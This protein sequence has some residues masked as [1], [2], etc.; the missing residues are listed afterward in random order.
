MELILILSAVVFFA[1]AV[2]TFS[3]FAGAMV[4]ITVGAHF[5][6]IERLVPVWVLINLVMNSY[7]ILRHRGHVAWSLIIKQ[8]LPFMCAG[9]LF[10]LWLYPHL[11][12]LPLK[13]ILGGLIVFFAG[14]QL[15]LMFKSS[16]DSSPPLSRWK[17]G[18]WQFLAGGCQAIY[19]AGGPFLVYS[20]NRISLAKS[21]FR[22]TLCTVWAMTNAAL[23]AAFILNGRLDSTAITTMLSLLPALPV[24][25]FLGEMMHGRVNERQF[26]LSILIMLLVAGTSLIF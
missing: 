1:S 11:E 13:R 15:V 18:F 23:I 17:A 4:A 24:G 5:Y 8:V 2:E 9:I 26:R 21:V 3:G 16:P 25:I 7:I 20:L 10:G 22:A 12:G 19:A 14:G 6:P